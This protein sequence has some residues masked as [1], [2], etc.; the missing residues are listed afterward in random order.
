MR[1]VIT[2]VNIT[3]KKR[4]HYVIVILNIGSKLVIHGISTMSTSCVGG[5]I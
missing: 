3:E 1:Y 5:T 4:Y 2:Y